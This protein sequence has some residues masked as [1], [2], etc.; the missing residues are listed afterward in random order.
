MLFYFIDVTVGFG[1]PVSTKNDLDIYNIISGPYQIF[2]LKISL[3][4]FTEFQARL[5]LP[6]AGPDK[7]ILWDIPHPCL[8]NSLS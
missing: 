3:C 7:M 4:I 2:N 6:L 5:W 8:N 1:E